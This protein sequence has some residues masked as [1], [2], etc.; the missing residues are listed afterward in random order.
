MPSSGAT[1]LALDTPSLTWTA[2]GHPSVPPTRAAMLRLRLQLLPGK[3]VVFSGAS[4]EPIAAGCPGPC[5]ARHH[6]PIRWAHGS[7]PPATWTR[8]Q[9]PWLV[10]TASLRAEN[11]LH[12]RDRARE[13]IP[14]AIVGSGAPHPGLPAWASQRLA[15][16]LVIFYVLGLIWLWRRPPARPGLRA[17]LETAGLLAGPLVAG[18]RA[19]FRHGRHSL[20]RRRLRGGTRLRGLARLARPARTLRIAA[21]Q[22]CGTMAH[23][24]R[25]ATGGHRAGDGS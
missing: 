3:A 7:T 1:D 15:A 5:P 18:G 10:P 20:A 25:V 24:L 8:G 16:V 17:S 4:L 19:P 12:W 22:R 14:A 2:D 9:I 21:S 11:L 13:A 23:A 6:A